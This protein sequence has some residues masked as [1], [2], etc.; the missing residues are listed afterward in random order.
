[1][2]RGVKFNAPT[3]ISV[4][5]DSSEGL[6]DKAK[7]IDYEKIPN[8]VFVI[9]TIFVILISVIYARGKGEI[10]IREISGLL[11]I[12]EAIGRATEMGK[13]VLFV[14]GLK[15]IPAVS[16]IAAM[17]VL[18]RIA[19]KTSEYDIPL[20]NPHSNA[21][22]MLIAQNV[23]KEAYTATGKPDKF[24]QDN[25]FFITDSQFAYAAAVDGIMMRD[26]PATIIYMGTF[27]AES[28]IFAE[29]GYA[30]G[31]IQIAGTDSVAQLPFFIPACDYTLMGEELFA[32]SAYLSGNPIFKGS[33]LGQDIMK[34]F[35]LSI[36][37]A[38]LILKLFKILD[39]S[40]LFQ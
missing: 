21:V 40:F 35:I 14:P 12:E 1:L 24:D 15:P 36:I 8:F 31:A 19:M 2:C 18:N 9:L 4:K 27:Y 17:D 6:Q 37:I 26:K 29:T 28:L 38:G 25:I 11:A 22:T 33:L 13:P 7:L 10:Y 34:I 39:I 16:A 5:E 23:I 32:A 20:I 3:I 30:A